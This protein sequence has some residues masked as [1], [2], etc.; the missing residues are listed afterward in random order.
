MKILEVRANNRKKAFEVRTRRGQYAFPYS[1]ADPQPSRADRV[2]ELSVDAELGREGFTY[3]LE[4]GS[5][6]SVH[7]DAVLEYNRDPSYLAELALYQL[8]A[9]AREAFDASPLSA[10]EVAR[11]LG[12]SPTQLYRLL[13]PT[14]YSKSLRQ[15]L[16]LLHVLGCEVDITVRERP[17]RK[18]AG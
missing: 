10:R 15:V 17:K 6:G 9:R 8:T 4:S 2:S 3:K 14:N 18:V 7:V 12:T 11:R 16:S 1:Q 5:E 13:D